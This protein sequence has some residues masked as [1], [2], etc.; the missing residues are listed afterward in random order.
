MKR[1]IPQLS[2]DTK[3]SLITGAVTIALFVL[4]VWLFLTI[5]E[6]IAN[7]IAPTNT[8]RT[9]TQFLA[10]LISM[11]ALLPQVMGDTIR[12]FFFRVL[13][14]R[15]PDGVLRTIHSLLVAL[16]FAGVSILPS[17][18]FRDELLTKN[19]SPFAIV[20][21][22]LITTFV[23][24]VSYPLPIYGAND[25]S[26]AIIHEFGYDEKIL[27][28]LAIKKR[29]AAAQYACQQYSLDFDSARY[30]LCAHEC[31]DSEEVTA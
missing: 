15:F 22:V 1:N 20:L 6:G 2:I 30:L 17:L 9:T 27:S 11:F 3:V 26:K 5:P 10:V 13:P 19:I 24:R 29:Y 18:Y 16:S 31:R 4:A 7:K 12:Q 25:R 23:W 21:T 28:L 8:S 14:L